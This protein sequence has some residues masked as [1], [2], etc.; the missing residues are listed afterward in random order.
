MVADQ[1]DVVAGGDEEVVEIGPGVA[2]GREPG[3]LG[4]FEDDDRPV[5]CQQLLGAAQRRE[6]GAL[7]VDLDQIDPRCGVVVAVPLSPLVK[8]SRSRVSHGTS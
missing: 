2:E 4:A 1:P 7:D 3:V 6:L 8:N 5:P